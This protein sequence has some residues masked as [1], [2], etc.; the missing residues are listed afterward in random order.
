MKGGLVGIYADSNLDLA[1]ELIK[2]ASDAG[3]SSIAVMATTAASLMKLKSQL[4]KCEHVKLGLHVTCIGDWR[5]E[6]SEAR[7]YADIVVAEPRS[8]QSCRSAAS[9]RGVDLIALRILPRRLYFDDVSAR[10][11]QERG[12]A[13]I[14]YASDLWNRRTKELQLGLRILKTELRIASARK[15][16]LILGIEAKTRWD[17]RSPRTIMALGHVMLGLD[18]PMA[19]SAITTFPRIM[20]ERG[21]ELALLRIRGM[22]VASQNP[23]Q[24]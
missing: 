2:E 20:L 3:Y 13:V 18:L 7:R 15:I 9:H 5:I 6:V 1:R 16:P 14:A 19:A 23:D 24:S 17:I 4:P 21:K 22:R 10:Q 11:M 8:L 12:S